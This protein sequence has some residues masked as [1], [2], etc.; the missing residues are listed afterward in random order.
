MRTAPEIK[1][2]DVYQSEEVRTW[3][4]RRVKKLAARNPEITKL[5]VAV[6]TPHR[7]RSKG[8][9][10]RVQIDVGI[11]GSELVACNHPNA[12]SEHLIPALYDA[13][14]RSARQLD[15]HRAARRHRVRRAHRRVG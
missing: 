7:R 4:L 5:R 3:I 10:F 1:V 12:N 8:R 11:P 13:F 2:Q 9:R 14:Q 15:E 6:N